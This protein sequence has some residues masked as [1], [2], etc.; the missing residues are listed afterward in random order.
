MD[1]SMF[2]S[3]GICKPLITAYDR[4]IIM[5]LL[6]SLNDISNGIPSNFPRFLPCIA[7]NQTGLCQ[8]C[9]GSSA[10]R[11]IF[12]PIVRLVLVPEGYTSTTSG[13]GQTWQMMEFDKDGLDRTI[14]SIE[15]ALGQLESKDKLLAGTPIT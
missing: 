11:D 4:A 5:Q 1:S 3:K 15:E 7:C 9:I 12:K 6:I 2:L 10:L 13:G 8:Y 14:G